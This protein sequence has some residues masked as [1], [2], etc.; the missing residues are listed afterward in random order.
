MNEIIWKNDKTNKSLLFLV[1]YEKYENS[2]FVF[3][4]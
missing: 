2:S 4:F 3:F 1:T